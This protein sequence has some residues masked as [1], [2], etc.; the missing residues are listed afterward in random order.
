M[1]NKNL[2]TPNSNK[3][4]SRQGNGK[5]TKGGSPGACGGNKTYKKAYRGQ[6]KR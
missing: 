5:F 2:Y 3:K 1:K 4:K 6:G